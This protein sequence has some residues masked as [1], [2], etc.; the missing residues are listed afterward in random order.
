MIALAFKLTILTKIYSTHENSD[1]LEKRRKKTR[2]TDIDAWCQ[3]KIGCK[4][5]LQHSSSSVPSRTPSHEVLEIWYFWSAPDAFEILLKTNS[6]VFISP[7]R[8]TWFT[9]LF[10]YRFQC[11]MCWYCWNCAWYFRSSEVSSHQNFNI[12]IQFQ[13][14][15]PMVKIPFLFSKAP[16]RKICSSH[17]RS[18]FLQKVRSRN[19]L[20]MSSRNASSYLPFSIPHRL[21][22]LVQVSFF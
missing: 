4:K 10:H 17:V 9:E 12:D 3:Q 2:R 8:H 21:F 5:N 11:R 20:S 18:C 19:M 16:A 6:Y 22:V 15:L 7:F 13:G 14:W 1:Y